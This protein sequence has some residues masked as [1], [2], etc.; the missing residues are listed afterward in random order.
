MSE[1]YIP[2]QR[3]MTSIEFTQIFSS[4]IISSLCFHEEL[5]GVKI[6]PDSECSFQL[7]LVKLDKQQFELYVENTGNSAIDIN[8]HNLVLRN[9]SEYERN[10][11]PLDLLHIGKR[12][13]ISSSV[14]LNELI[15]KGREE[16]SF[17][18]KLG[19]FWSKKDSE[20]T[21]EFN[22]EPIPAKYFDA[23]NHGMTAKICDPS[24]SSV[25]D[26]CIASIDS[27][28]LTTKDTH[29]ETSEVEIHS[30][31]FKLNPPAQEL[32]E[33]KPHSDLKKEN[34][35]IAINSDPSYLATALSKEFNSPRYADWT[36]ICQNIE[37][38]CHKLILQ[39]RSNVL[40]RLLEPTEGVFG[41]YTEIQD[42]DYY[43]LKAMLKF[44]YTDTIDLYKT[45]VTRLFAAADQY[46]I[47]LLLAM[48]ENLL[49]L[50]LKA[51]TV[52]TCFQL[53]ILHQK[54]TLKEK[55]MNFIWKNWTQVKKTQ[56][57]SDLVNEYNS[58]YQ[59]E[60]L[61]EYVCDQSMKKQEK[62]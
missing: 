36:I 45:S 25:I 55:C 10:F 35:Q 57:W 40:K 46:N 52:A 59:I 61:I 47:P 48:C 34:S 13:S 11:L 38:P 6:F 8:V 49:A 56:S 58:S 7:K 32:V 24:A 27:A 14:S 16:I 20:S 60:E 29:R 43:T 33:I 37:I 5:S 50:N 42:L 9:G 2:A 12:R 18:V 26:V 3:K 41:G 17:T 4:E 51:D 28:K 54:Q 1:T 19:L 21:T 15:I 31:D 30:T 62:F 53:A 22:V 23:P 44:I 39:A